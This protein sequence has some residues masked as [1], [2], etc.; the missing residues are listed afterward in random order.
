MGI[1]ICKSKHYKYIYST[2]INPICFSC[3]C[4]SWPSRGQ[5]W[6]CSSPS[7]G[8]R[9]APWATSPSFSASSYSSLPSWACS[10][11]AKATQVRRNFW[12]AFITDLGQQFNVSYGFLISTIISWT[13][14]IFLGSKLTSAVILEPHWTLDIWVNKLPNTGAILLFTVF[15]MSTT[16][17]RA[18]WRYIGII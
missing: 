2:H 1:H 5:H 14:D 4:S 9:W 15:N 7:W 18:A 8:R 10:S 3:V 16:K 17:Y 11:S 12:C 6:T 13:C